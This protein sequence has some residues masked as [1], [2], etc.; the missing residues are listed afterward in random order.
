MSDFFLT[1]LNPNRDQH[2]ISPH[3]NTAKSF[4]K[5]MRLKEMITNLRSSLL[6]NKSSL[7]ALQEMCGEQYK[8]CIFIIYIYIQIG[9]LCFSQ[10]KQS[11]ILLSQGKNKQTTLSSQQACFVIKSLFRGFYM[12]MHIYIYIYMLRQGKK[13]RDYTF[14]PTSLFRDCSLIK[15]FDK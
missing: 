7:S 5:I 12:Y 9:S 2:L 3:S 1:L 8:E 6:L 15:G 13:Q 10:Q 11:V 14:I 4:S